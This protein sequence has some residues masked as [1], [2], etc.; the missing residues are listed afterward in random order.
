MNK[1]SK[2]IIL[3][4]GFLAVLEA[5]SFLGFLHPLVNQIIFIALLVA[6]IIITAYSLENGLLI[7]L[8][9]LIV[10]SKGYLFYLPYSDEKMLSLRLAIWSVF[11]LIF[12]FKLANQLIRLGN[13][14]EYLARMKK[15]IFWRPFLGLAI[16]VFLGLI[17]GLIYHNGITNIF[18]DF[19]AWLYFLILLPASAL[20]LKT[21]KLKIIFLAGALL[22][23]LK[24]L[25]LLGLF[26][27]NFS[28]APTIYGWLRKTLVGEMTAAS[29]WNRVFIQSQIFP[30]IAYYFLL[31]K[32]ATYG[33]L[34]DIFKKKNWLNLIIAALFFSTLLISLSRSFWFGFAV[35]II[36]ALVIV[37]RLY[38]LKRVL[39][40]S[41][42]LFAS[43]V[44]GAL[45]IMAVTP[46]LIGNLDNQVT[47]RL[48]NKQEAAVVSRWSL[49][50]ALVKEIKKN[51]ISGQGFG[52]TVTYISSDPRVIQNNLGGAYTTYAF[53]WGYLD[54]WLKIGILGLIAYFWLFFKLIKIAILKAKGQEI[55]FYFSLVAGLI[56]LAALNIFT[57]YLNHPLG[58]GFILIS[59]C[60][61]CK[62]RVY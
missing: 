38:S 45:M 52:A 15:F 62:D 21:E 46:K 20:D 41:V 5:L 3:I 17:S 7:V 56:F 16:F 31:F 25:I 4:L 33:R 37:W 9:E 29:G 23:A 11:M 10:G 55:G 13:K 61:I 36:L 19:N 6:T 28:F 51:P 58:I 50:P 35:A 43:A 53:E 22:V 14:S 24:T 49:L 27:N 8:T 44:L 26:S 32:A 57:P 60:L 42:W 59:S 48:G 12:V 2:N 39:I 30:I 47:G 54:I 40:I 34:A 1:L 18:L